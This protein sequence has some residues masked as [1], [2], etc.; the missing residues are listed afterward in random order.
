MYAADEKRSSWLDRPVSLAK[1][2]QWETILFAAILL[3]AVVT[4]FYKLEPRVMSH[5]ETS[6]VYFS[7]LLYTGQGYQHDPVTHGP[8]QFHVVAL[9]YFLFG[10]SDTSAR[11]PAVLFSIATVG[12]MWFYRRYLGRLGALAAALMFVV[13]PYM[14]Y[15][16]RY[17]RNEAFV[18]LWGVLTI[19]AILRYLE[20]GKSQYI[21]GLTAAIVLHYTTKETVYIYTAQALL[22]L[23]L[24]FVYRQLQQKWP[25]DAARRHFA[26]AL[27]VALSGAAVWIMLKLADRLLRAPLSA[28]AA[29]LVPGQTLPGIAPAVMLI[30]LA[31]TAAALL[32]AIYFLVSGHCRPAANSNEMTV[33]LVALLAIP[34]LIGAAM[35]Y[36]LFIGQSAAVAELVALPTETPPVAGATPSDDGVRTGVLLTMLLVLPTLMGV[37]LFFAG[38]YAMRLPRLIWPAGAERS[39]D[40]LIV[41]GTLILPT[42]SAFLVKPLGDPLDY[43]LLGMARTASVLIPVA[44]LA[45]GL[46]V[47]W[48]TKIWLP[49]AALF[50]A[51]FVVLYTTIFTNGGGFFTGL[52]GS[53]GYWLEQQGVNRGTQPWYYYL[54]VQVPVYEYLPALGSLLALAFGVS[55]WLRRRR[56]AANAVESQPPDEDNEPS[57]MPTPARPGELQ[58]PPVLTF[59]GFWAFTSVLAYSYAGEKMPWLTVH[60]ALP[61]ILLAGWA[62]GRA[63]AN[64]DFAAFRR[65]RGWLVTA[66]TLLFLVSFG[67]VMTS[68]LGPNPPF[69]GKE[70]AQLTST[71]TF[72]TALATLILS[73]WGLFSLLRDWLPGQFFRL[74]GGILIVFLTLLTARAAFMA[75]Y[76]NYD[77][78]TEYLVYAHCGPGIKDALAQIEELSLRTTGALAMTVAYDNDTTYPYWWYLRDYTAQRYYGAN[79][80][81]ELRDVPVILV[82]QNNF[83]KI[84]PVVGQAYHK[85]EYIRIWWP[86]EDY[87]NLTFE[88][89]WHAITNRE[90][91]NAIFQIWLNR[92]Y[93]EYAR[94][95]GKDFLTLENWS[96][97][98][99]FRLYVRKDIVAQLWNYGTV[100]LPEEVVADPYEGKELKLPADKM[101]GVA[102]AAEGQFNAP[103]GVAVAA[104]GTLYVADTFN[105]RIQHLTADGAVLHV[106]G[107]FANVEAGAAPVGTFNEPWGIAVGPDGS[108]YVAD[109][110]NHRIQKFSADGA[111]ITVWGHGI[112]QDLADPYGFYGPRGVAVDRQG[113]VYVSDTGNKRIVV[114]DGEG[115][116]IAQFGEG[117]MAAGYFDEPVGV[118]VSAEGL[119]YVA[120][121][122]NQRVQVIMPSGEGQ[123]LPLRQWEIYGWFGQL[124]DNKPYLAVNSLGH[125]FVTDPE[126]YR[127]LEF[128]AEGKFVRYWGDYGADQN[129]LNL[130][131]G[132]AVDPAGGIWVADAGNNRVVHFTPP[133]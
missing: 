10:D 52:I 25:N 31:L 67:G 116:F 4:R 38:R 80:T 72:I 122:W 132:I 95:T 45:I 108:V 104:D 89:I 99:R 46:G 106:W 1:S 133:K 97:A 98:E 12:F 129:G 54:L 87:K 5:D 51:I 81:R 7:W 118:A 107:G 9:A 28:Q 88:R 26:M 85:F 58:P 29:P 115:K 18:A 91:R 53:L 62:F 40:L 103:R 120:D 111:F 113:S 55:D 90:M 13:S 79:P 69:Q 43:S 102:G 30:P 121:T 65:Q 94:L 27:L 37:G 39:L 2:L 83:S 34:L 35:L 130:P 119:V 50:Y 32:A 110:W 42:L 21:L 17:V 82:G 70:L 36:G 61:F 71:G 23:A 86:D 56:E 59:I 19:W 16:G 73:G 66:T 22:F 112:S 41:I 6:H 78:A 77:R 47:G 84:E 117:G 3:L 57:L 114:F 24:Y 68:L 128:D 48:D 15:Y 125:V 126:S 64:F 74:M 123:Y 60:I 20:T 109:T 63:L 92:D 75:S 96:P 105:H 100:S 14:L 124:V 131:T 101:I 93:D 49:N 44:M 33:F 8:F 11:I 127:I 76:I